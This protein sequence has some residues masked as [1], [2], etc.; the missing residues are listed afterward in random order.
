MRRRYDLPEMAGAARVSGRQSWGIYVVLAAAVVLM[1]GVSKRGGGQPGGIT[2]AAE[3]RT[4]PPLVLQLLDG[5][6]WRLDDHRGQVVVVNYW[7]SWCGPCWEETPGLVRLAREDRPKGLAVVGVSVDEGGL[8][9][10]RGFVQRLGVV[11]PIALSQP[12]SQMA[13]G[14]G[15][16]PTTFLVDRQ[17]RVAKSYSGAVKERDLRADAEALLEEQ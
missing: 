8:D 7:A 14:L 12:M 4:M 13:Y 11:Y 6:T 15:G 1:V 5:G 9:K 10:V 3:R 17:G 2:P 16:V